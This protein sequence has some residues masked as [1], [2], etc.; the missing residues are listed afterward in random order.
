MVFWGS[1]GAVELSE[2]EGKD[3]LEKEEHKIG[4]CSVESEGKEMSRE[5]IGVCGGWRR[6]I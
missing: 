5:W 6:S 3:E 1:F 2:S 4:L